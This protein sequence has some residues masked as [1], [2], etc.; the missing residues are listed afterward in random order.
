MLPVLATYEDGAGTDGWIMVKENL[1]TDQYG[2][3]L[4][5]DLDSS[6]TRS[7]EKFRQLFEQAGCKIIK[8]EVQSGFPK[9]LYPVK[10]YALRPS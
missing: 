4:F 5:D 1:S 9:S 7:D 10:M 6:V 8:M 2:E 3:D